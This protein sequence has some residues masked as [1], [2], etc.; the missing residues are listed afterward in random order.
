MPDNREQGP[1]PLISLSLAHSNAISARMLTLE[2]DCREIERYLDGFNGIYYEYCGEIPGA[3]RQRIRDLLAEILN[4]ILLLRLDLGLGKQRVEIEKLVAS[5]LSHMWVTLHESKA[6][7]LKGFG[8]V[9]EELKA[10]IDPRVEELLSLWKRFSEILSEGS[11]EGAT[12]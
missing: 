8:V 6:S 11:A 10:Y 5:R 2:E 9:P 12:K 3:I 4:G 1:Q 7:N